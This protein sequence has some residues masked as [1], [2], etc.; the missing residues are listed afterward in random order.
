M[1]DRIVDLSAERQVIVFTHNI[2]FT[3]ELLNRFEK[4]PGDCKYYEVSA[5]DKVPGKVEALQHPKWDTPS[6]IGKQIHTRIQTAGQQSGIM[7]EDLIRGAW[8]QIRSWCEAFIE[9]E[10]L[11]DVTARYRPHVRMTA[12]PNIKT[13]LLNETVVKVLP[14]FEKACRITDA[15]SQPLE[16]LCVKPALEELIEDWAVLQ[17]ERKKYVN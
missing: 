14:I 17:A 9:K 8:G 4:R 13:A 2:W 12:L 10:V 16:T 7:R 15:H 1:V 3:A 11:A 5:E 6:Q